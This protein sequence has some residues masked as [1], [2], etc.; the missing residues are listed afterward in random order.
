M[1]SVEV[2]TKMSMLWLEDT[3]LFMKKLLVFGESIECGKSKTVLANDWVAQLR[4]RV[5]RKPFS[6]V[7]NKF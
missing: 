4:L 3:P 6:T 5:D 2:M 1:K 7:A